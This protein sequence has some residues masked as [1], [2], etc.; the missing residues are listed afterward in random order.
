VILIRGTIKVLV[1]EL[2]N[3]K[4]SKESDFS[5]EFV[6]HRFRFLKRLRLKWKDSMKSYFY[7]KYLKKDMVND[8][9]REGKFGK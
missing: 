7:H 9:I 4:D 3:V 8:E 6:N 2:E 1:L 5:L